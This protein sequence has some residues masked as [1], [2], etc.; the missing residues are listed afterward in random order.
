M[1][2]ILY[3][4]IALF[5]FSCKEE[6]LEPNIDFESPF[7]I[8]ADPNNPV[9]QKRFELYEEYGVSVYF[10]DT[11]NTVYVNKNVHGDSVFKYEFLDLNWKFTA[12]SDF[13]YDF[14]YFSSQEDRLRALANVEKY[15]QS[16]IPSLR[17]FSMLLV[18]DFTFNGTATDII[19]HIEGSNTVKSLNSY[20]TLVVSNLH[21]TYSEDYWPG[22]VT[23]LAKPQIKIAIARE[24]LKAKLISFQTVSQSIHYNQYW[25]NLD[26][27]PVPTTGFTSFIW[28]QFNPT[29]PSHWT[30]PR[31]VAFRQVYGAYGFIGVSSTIGFWY[32]PTLET[33]QNHYID[34]LLNYNQTIFERNWEALPLVMEKYSIMRDILVNELNIPLD[35]LVK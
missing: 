24:S 34:A 27:V 19:S 29:N 21:K 5:F 32:S 33:D 8:K 2:K 16:S 15:L 28:S 3:F 6:A 4:F 13:K 17:P 20:R 22:L 7:V 12:V 30:D 1:K 23:K 18:D 25:A 31:Y 11:V 35:Q 26:L 14:K 9:N 10:S